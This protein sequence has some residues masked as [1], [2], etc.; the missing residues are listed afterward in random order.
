MPGEVAVSSVRD[1]PPL[2]CAAFVPRP[3]ATSGRVQK[4]GCLR[5]G[6]ELARGLVRGIFGY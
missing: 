4:A 3:T 6:R 1:A 5:Q 2:E